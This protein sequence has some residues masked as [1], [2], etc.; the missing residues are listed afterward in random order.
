MDQRQIVIY[1]RDQLTRDLLKEWLAEAGYEVRIGTPHDARCDRPAELVV[2]SVYLPKCAGLE[3]VRS[4]Q[5]AHPG[6]PIIAIS[7][8]FR[9]GLAPAG[10]A[11]AALN[12]QQVLAKPLVRSQVLRAVSAIMGHPA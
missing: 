3:C 12:V 7:G 11:A 5:T 9:S 10:A 2:V 8:H 4:I 6:T 1:E